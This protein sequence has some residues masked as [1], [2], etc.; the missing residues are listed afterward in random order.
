MKSKSKGQYRI[1][2]ANIERIAKGSGKKMRKP[3]SAGAPAADAF[4]ESAKT[5]KK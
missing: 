5:A 1:A 4:K 3:G 2:L